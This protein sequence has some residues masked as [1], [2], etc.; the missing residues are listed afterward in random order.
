LSKLSKE[1]VN[2]YADKTPPWGE[3]GYVVYKRTYARM[4]DGLGRT[5]EWHET[6]ERVVNGLLEM[7]ADYSMADAEDL[8]DKLFNFKGMVSGRA[9]WQMGTETV[10]RVGSDS[11]SNCW[12]V[13]LDNLEAFCFT[14]NQLMLGGGVGY[15]LQ[16][17]HVYTL[18]R[19]AYSP[20]IE[21]VETADCDFIVTDN[22]EGWVELLRRVLDSFFTSG[23][24]LRYSTQSIRP[25]GKS[26]KSFGGVASGSESLVKGISQIVEVIRLRHGRKLRPVDCLDVMNIIGSVVVSGN[27]RRSA[28]IALGDV[29][30]RDFMLAKNWEKGSIPNWRAMSNN[31]VVVSSIDDLNDDFWAGYNGS[32]EPYGIINLD[33]CRAMGRAGDYSRPDPLVTGVNPCLHPDERISTAEGLV[34]IGTL[35]GRGPQSVTVRD[36]RPES[37]TQVEKTGTDVD[38]YHVLTDHGHVI[39]CSATHEFPTQAGRVEAQDLNNNHVLELQFGVGGFGPRSDQSKAFLLGSL[40]GAT[41]L[42]DRN[43]AMLNS[44]GLE[45]TDSV[46]DFI[47]E[48]DRE[49]V[50]KYLTGVLAVNGVFVDSLRML[51]T[52][53]TFLRDIQKLLANFAVVSRVSRVFGMTEEN[54]PIYEISINHANLIT[55]EE[56]VDDEWTDLVVALDRLGRNALVAETYTTRVTNV[57]VDGKSD[58]YCLNQPADHTIVV[59]GVVTGQCAEI[60][61]EDREP[62]NLSDIYLPNIA[63]LDE[64]K[65]VAE[66]LYIACKTITDAGYSD[67]ITQE[68]VTRNRRI[69]IGLTGWMAAPQWRDGDLLDQVYDH[70]REFDREYSKANGMN[71]SIKMTTMK[72]SGSLSL[73]P[74]NVTPGMHAAYGRFLIRRIRFA[75]SD[76]LVKVC[77]DHGYHVEPQINLDGTFNHDTMVV[78]F[79][80][81]F[82]ESTTTEDQMTAIDQLEQQKML[83]THWSD[84]SVSATHYFR[85]NELDR[86]KVWLTENFKSVKTASFLPAFEH[87]FKQAPL[88]KI[89]E[90][91]YLEMKAKTRPITRLVEDAQQDFV[92]SMECEGGHCP[93]K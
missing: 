29:N 12:Q 67:P 63:D 59:G 34:C 53:E 31:S 88:E 13:T 32:G 46:P 86:I 7:G 22:R 39:R 62:C 9:L 80:M 81:A 56:T 42:S 52:S 78:S 51:H 2:S 60:T 61:L 3:V 71:E 33:A 38:I 91:Q 77:R 90:E 58:V 65:R 27:V 8:Y 26:I 6:V 64:F 4:I 72:P 75:S 43:K 57:Y 11:L 36:G 76:P 20:V 55:F 66:L 49:T 44:L 68:V 10:R 93:I 24:N 1:F 30:D 16:A 5:E 21:R 17:E 23:R 37:A 25:S 45:F 69:G 74:R 82:D 83:Q 89:T 19:V 40:I 14:F 84:N 92:E 79:P 85:P 47:F 73:L 87:G 15:N 18:P 70:L 28:Q 50:A 35:V 48:C 54:R 41:Q